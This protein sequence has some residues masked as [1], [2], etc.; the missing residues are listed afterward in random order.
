MFDDTPS[1]LGQR[2]ALRVD[3]G[4]L[5]RTAHAIAQRHGVSPMLAAVMAGRG[6]GLDDAESYLNPT[7][8]NL[9]PD[10]SHLK[11]MEDAVARIQKALDADETI[12]VFGDYDVDG[13]TSS[14]LLVRYFRLLGKEL[15][16]YIPDRMGEGYGPNT[17]AF[18]QLAEQGV[19]LIITVDCGTV[20]YEPVEAVKAKGVDVIVVDHHVAE[21]RLPE[22]I[23]VNPNR[24]DQ[25]S[26]CGHLAAVGVTFLLLVALNR[27]LREAGT[28]EGKAEPNLLEWLDIVALGTVCDVMQLTT[29]N[30]AFVSQGLK[31]MRERRNVGIRAL[32]DH[33]GLDEVPN[34]YHLGFV[35]GPRINAGGR[36]GQANLGV[37]L[38]TEEDELQASRYAQELSRYNE[39]RRA[40]EM[41]V[42]EQATEKAERQSNQA[43]ICVSGEGWHEGVIGIVA[44]RIKEQFHRPA[45][46][47]AL[48]EGMGKASARS[49]TGVDIGAAI[50]AACQ[51]G[52]LEA[53]GGHAMAG[54]FSVKAEKL[55]ELLAFFDARLHEKV[56]EYQ[57]GRTLKLDALLTPAALT[58][59]LMQQIEQGAPYG[60]G[61]PSPRFALE[62]IR[63]LRRVVL[64]GEH[65]KLLITDK[66]RKDAPRISAMAFRAMGGPLEHVLMGSDE[67][68]C[69]AGQ[70]KWNHWNGQSSIQF[71]IDDA[72]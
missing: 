32:F 65:I 34:T 66:S 41:S 10:P 27:A 37:K 52:L 7:L 18:M 12:A 33:A 17:L 62:N 42:L 3:G 6:I 50:I 67:H 71:M 29:L 45:A 25:T 9:M 1:A 48:N 20:A 21:A 54:G 40:I 5:E 46:V 60:Q 26:E 43:V 68:L 23:V 2:W 58:P 11:G 28:F 24:M 13:A 4:E 51:T 64:K 39:E 30:R 22:A 70:P 36:V 15:I 72:R 49:V 57:E 35:L 31:R 14:A 16:T 44:G 61:N 47:I 55:D 8:K 38:L 69:L 56:A 63:V 53:G 19:T 59:D